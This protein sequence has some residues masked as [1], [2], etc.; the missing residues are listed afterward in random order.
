MNAMA[1]L[2]VLSAWGLGTLLVAALWPGPR[3]RREELA[4]ILPLGLL[5]GLGVT[6]AIFFGASLVSARAAMVGGIVE[7][8]LGVALVAWLWR[9]RSRA[10]PPPAAPARALSWRHALIGAVF[11]QAAVASVVV[12]WR[13]YRAEPFGGGDGWAIW[14][15]HARFMLRGGPAWPDLSASPQ[16][17]WSHP[18]YPRLVPASVARAWGWAGNESPFIA[19]LVSALFA[20]ATVAL[21]MAI[22]ARLRGRLA[23][24]AGGLVLLG[25]PFFLTFASNEHADIPLGAFML[26]AVALALRIE[27]TANPRGGWALAGIFTGLAAWTKNEGLLF[28]VIFS[29]VWIAREARRGGRRAIA[30]FVLGLVPALLPVG[31]FKLLLAPANDLMA[32]PLGPRLGQLFDVARHRLLLTSLWRD[33]RAFGEWGLLPFL[34]MLLPLLVGV[35]GWVV[36]GGRLVLAISALMLAGYYGVYLLSPMNLAGHIDSSLVRLL[37]QLWPL[38][39]LAWCLAL[40][41][42]EQVDI[43]PADERAMR[44]RARLVLFTAVNAITAVILLVVLSA[45]TTPHDLAVRRAGLVEI[46]A[47]LGDG[48]FDHERHGRD[49]WAWSRGRSTLLVH[50]DTKRGGVD[51]TLRFSLRGLVRQQVTIRLDGRVLWQGAVAEKFLPVELT[52]IP[53]AAGTNAIE[54]STDTPGTAESAA[55]GAR[56]LTFALYNVQL[57]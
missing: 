33:V 49:S 13:S 12:A 56:A 25:T 52:R 3:R 32:A 48:W 14:N 5:A 4:L 54:L 20:A 35:R 30:F 7:C 50:A 1:A 45:Q 9:R 29:A 53:L 28:A 31:C 57:R 27:G 44:P 41:W 43:P 22:V 34:P 19:A 8:A 23:A 24:L 16:L 51:S 38:M 36:A 39:L 40:P 15:M 10:V 17:N 55:P 37:L 11:F 2:A 21:L 46:S 42:A 26:A 18:D 6:S 47:A